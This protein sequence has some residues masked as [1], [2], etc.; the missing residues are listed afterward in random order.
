MCHAFAAAMTCS[1]HVQ[2]AGAKKCKKCAMRLRQQRRGNAK[3]HHKFAAAMPCGMHV[4]RAQVRKCKNAPC[5]C[6]GNAARRA[7]AAQRITHGHSQ[8]NAPGKQAAPCKVDCARA[9]RITLHRA[10]SAQ[11]TV[12]GQLSAGMQRARGTRCVVRAR[13][14]GRGSLVQRAPWMG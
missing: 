2:Q 8:C 1:M 6:G 7:R 13:A 3:T 9:R 10:R 11:R 4:Q 14:A 5:V 12:Q